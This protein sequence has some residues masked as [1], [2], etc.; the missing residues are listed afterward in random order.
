MSRIDGLL[1]QHC[2]DGVEYKLLGEVGEFIRGRRF[3]KNDYVESGLGCIHYGQIYTDYGTA[4]DSTV[5]FIKPDLRGSLRL[6]RKN[7]LVIAAT[8]EN[9]QD[10]CKAVAWLGEEEVAVHDDCYI[11]RHSFD[12]K[13]A[14][15]LFQSSIF[16]EQKV[17]YA[18]ESKVVRISGANLSKIKVPVPPLEVQNEIAE[19]LTTMETLETDLKAELNAELKA[20]KRQYAYY[21]DALLTLPGEGRT[22]WATLGELA[23]IGT[24]SH[25]TNEGLSVGEYPFFVRSQEVR[26]LQA[27]DFDE[28]AII[29]SGDGVGVGK[30][31]HYI[32]GKYALHQRAYRIHVTDPSLMPKFYFHYMRS[33]FGDYMERSAVRS[34]VTSVRRPM[35]ERYP[36]PVPDLLEQKRIVDT[37]D[38]LDALVNDYSASLPAEITARRQ[39]YTYYR[40]R[41]LTFEE[42]TAA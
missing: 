17:K 27:Y 35:L 21:Y 6:A 37:L 36:V 30:V 18:N 15:Y 13:F 22:K 12:P 26:R 34:S 14:S 10:V 19:I 7:D 41:L 16:Q 29:T 11:F 38:A 28:T 2:P 4:A 8:G 39:Q 40:D 1:K 5:A 9:I 33:T 25:N 3:T 23:E 32:E 42:K 24:G 20:R 31:F